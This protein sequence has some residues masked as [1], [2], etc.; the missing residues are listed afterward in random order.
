MIVSTVCLDAPKAF[1][2]I[3]TI[4]PPKTVGALVESRPVDCPAA[5][6]I[7]LI[8]PGEVS[9]DETDTVTSPHGRSPRRIAIDLNK[10]G[11]KRRAPT[12]T[13]PHQMMDDMAR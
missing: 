6:V 7:E 1:A 5:T 8:F 3:V 11:I 12:T 13:L 4:R 9:R 2:E 10:T